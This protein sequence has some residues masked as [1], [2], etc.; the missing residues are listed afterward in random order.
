LGQANRK[1]LWPS[2]R[3]TPKNRHLPWTNFGE[4][5]IRT[6]DFCY[7]RTLQNKERK[8]SSAH[9]LDLGMIGTAYLPLLIDD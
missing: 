3:L 6:G 4:F 5:T 9:G 8:T 2:T 1:N 7:G